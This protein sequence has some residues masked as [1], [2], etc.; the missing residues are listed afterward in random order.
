MSSLGPPAAPSRN[1]L[2]RCPFGWA[3]NLH[4]RLP[5]SMRE[6]AGL[7]ERF[8]FSVR[9]LGVG[10]ALGCAFAVCAFALHG[11][12]ASWLAAI[13]VSLV[14]I[15]G[16]VASFLAGW[17]MPQRYSGR[18]LWSIAMLM[19]LVSYAGGLGSLVGAGRFHD[20]SAQQWAGT[21]LEA[22]WRATPFQLI[23][24]LMMVLLAWASSASRRYLL[25]AE[26]VRVKLGNERDAAAAQLTQARLSLLQAQIQPHFLFNTLAALQH[27]VDIGDARAAPLLRALTSFLRGSTEL[28]SRPEVTLAQ[29]S[30]MARHYLSI[31]RSRLGDRLRFE[32][33]IAPDCATQPLPP[34]LLVTLVENAVEHGI[35]P[36][37]HGGRVDVVA[38]RRDGA[39][40]LRVLDDGVGLR[41]GAAGLVEGVGLG[42]SRE[43]L[44]HRF[45]DRARLRLG[46]RSDGPGTEVCLRL[47]DTGTPAP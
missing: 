32:I 16:F 38:R 37:L 27:W 39:F 12:G 43:R 14:M 46:L 18:K 45:G 5:A 20:Q 40:E 1:A 2:Q 31:M 33:D 23:A 13:L 26:L 21:L 44:R 25:Q 24:G 22:L 35:E 36:Q 8:M 19:A 41:A 30:E 47:E 29:E 17:L 42:N 15:A 11:R 4:A 34:G 28:M 10:L 3:A 7:I 6:P 9:G